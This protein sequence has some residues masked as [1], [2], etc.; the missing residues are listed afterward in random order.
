VNGEGSGSSFAVHELRKSFDGSPVLDGISLEAHACQRLG[1]I[2]PPGCGKSTLLRCIGGLMAPDAGR[3]VVDENEVDAPPPGS[4]MLFEHV[5]LF[6]WK[7]VF[8]NVAFGL[9]TAGAEPEEV[10]A[11]V[12][13]FLSLVGLSGYESAYPR[14]LSPGMQ[15]R[16]AIARAFAVRPRL[17]LVDDP[18]R[19]LDAQTRELL[20]SELLLILEDRPATLVFAT[21]SVDEALL[22]ADRI[23]VMERRPGR[24]HEV[25]DVPQPHPRSRRDLSDPSWSALCDRLW[26]TLSDE[27][28]RAQYDLER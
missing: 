12:P 26:Q 24:V 9:A 11:T 3:V 2:G 23:V 7:S 15:Q 5:G 20:Q 16:C 22:M 14:Q 8:D 27:A 6:P 28:R 25:F 10:A 1:V 21:R 17:L 18:F 4:A 13:Q 19:S